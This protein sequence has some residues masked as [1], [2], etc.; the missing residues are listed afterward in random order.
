MATVKSGYI[1]P[2]P[3]DASFDEGLYGQGHPPIVLTVRKEIGAVHP[4]MGSDPMVVAAFTLAGQYLNE[5]A[6]A[7][8]EEFM[9]VEF[10][11]GG[12]HFV[13]AFNKRS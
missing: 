5:Q 13:A 3:V 1:H 4:G 8:S 10:D 12:V 7:D 6:Q 11:H 9:E 2:E